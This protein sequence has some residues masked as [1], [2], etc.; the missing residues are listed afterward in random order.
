MRDTKVAFRYA[1]SLLLLASERNESDRIESD[2]DTIDKALSESREMRVFLNS[3]V[4]SSDKK[5]NVLL[6]VFGEHISEL[7][8]AF[9]KILTAKYRESLLH[10]IA[11]SFL[12]QIRR[13]KGILTA[14][15]VSADSLDSESRDTIHQLV[16][17]L[18]EGGEIVINEE[19]DPELIGG[20]KIKVDDKMV[21]ASVSSHLRK[22]RRNF[23]KNLYE[24][25][26]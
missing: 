25:S 17:E 18:N 4:V 5:Y 24:A 7:M 26:I 23:T 3:P 6:A 9:L 10:D 8:K 2:F 13:Q 1:K 21:D 15:V 20:F 11:V 22:L 19:I 12:E 14:T 16:K